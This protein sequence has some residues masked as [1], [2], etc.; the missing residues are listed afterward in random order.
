M[1]TTY[2]LG[3]DTAKEKI[4][5]ALRGTDERFLFEKDLPVSAAGL[6]ELLLCLKREITEPSQLLVLIEATGVLHLNWAAAL[7]R[8][9]YAVTVLNPLMA[10]RL[11][12]VENSIRD[13]KTDPVDARR[14]CRI[15]ALYGLKLWEKYA[16]RLEPE[17]LALQRLET[18][19]KAL[20]SALTK[21]MSRV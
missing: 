14:L 7:V 19:R 4:R 6:R 21:G 9:G 18:V 2:I 12:S 17:R 13:N 20:R 3:I 1:K 11:Y 15:G 8:A 10:R 5:A 16:Y